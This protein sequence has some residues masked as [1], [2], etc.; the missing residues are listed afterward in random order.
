LTFRCVKC[1]E[2][3]DGE[4]FY[5]YSGRR[6]SAC[7]VCVISANG[8]R[9]KEKVTELRV[10]QRERRR[11][12]ASG[13]EP[14]FRNW[15]GNRV[16]GPKQPGVVL[17]GFYP[18]HGV[19]KS[20]ARKE[21]SRKRLEQRLARRVEWERRYLTGFLALL[22]WVNEADRVEKGKRL[23]QV[24][25]LRAVRLEI[26]KKK[27]REYER[28]KQFRRRGAPG[29]YTKADIDRLFLFQGGK[30]VSCLCGLKTGYHVDHVLPI[31]LGGTNDPKN[32][33]LLCAPC[34]LRKGAKHP[35]DYAQSLGRL[36]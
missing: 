28:L 29:R 34:N 32:L 24:V 16:L 1:G 14:V 26:A 12:L 35:V 30:C 18:L 20:R 13:R 10:Y 25:E 8:R 11:M 21:L 9:N 17:R 6:W 27:R 19:S 3:K 22:Y 36:L 7:R 15:T 2:W 33:Q 4:G 5:R 31:A 23:A